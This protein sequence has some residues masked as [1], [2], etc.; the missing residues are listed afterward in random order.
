MRTAMTG[1][2]V[3]G[4]A[5]VAVGSTVFRVATAPERVRDRVETAKRVC[6]ERGGDWVK[7][8]SRDQCRL[9]GTTTPALP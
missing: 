8:D 7:V 3:F 4:V 1:F 5:V 6:A 2:L 9:P